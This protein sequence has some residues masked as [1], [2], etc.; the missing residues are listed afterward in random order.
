MKNANGYINFG[1]LRNKIMFSINNFEPIL[2]K[3]IDY[4]IK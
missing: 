4:K 2:N 1:R 3:K